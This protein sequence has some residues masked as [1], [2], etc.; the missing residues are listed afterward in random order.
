M[1]CACEGGLMA[2]RRYVPL[3]LRPKLVRCFHFPLPSPLRDP[4]LFNTPS[5]SLC[6]SHPLS[7]YL[8]LSLFPSFS[9]TPPSRARSHIAPPRRR[10]DDAHPVP[11]LRPE[12][13]FSFC[14][15]CISCVCVCARRGRFF[16]PSQFSGIVRSVRFSRARDIFHTHKKLNTL[17]HHNN[18]HNII[19]Y[20]NIRTI[21]VNGHVPLLHTPIRH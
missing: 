6:L 9:L 10:R 4:P 21:A 3:P 16:S 19:R 12:V 2:G 7:Q 15:A 20:N 1:G 18:A 13:F 11:F 17:T 14:L 8:S 5:L